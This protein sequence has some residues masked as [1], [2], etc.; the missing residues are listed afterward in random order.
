MRRTFSIKFSRKFKLNVLL[1]P[2]ESVTATE[3]SEA[4]ALT[5]MIT[6][7]TNSRLVA[8]DPHHLRGERRAGPGRSPV[9]SPT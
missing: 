6:V 5:V 8:N 9:L 4:P 7:I 2:S 1:G 3:V